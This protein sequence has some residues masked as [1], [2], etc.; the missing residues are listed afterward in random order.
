M[1]YL[2]DTNIVSAY[3]KG[4]QLVFNQLRNASRDNRVTCIS[5]IT[6]YEIRRGLLYTNATRQLALFDGFCATS[7]IL[8]LDNLEMIEIAARIHVDLSRRGR[9][10]QDNDI[11]IAATAIANNLTLVSNDTD[12]QNI[13]PL[14]L[15]NWL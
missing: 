6:Y 10:I 13:Q 1:G 9:P 2:L 5:C 8:L 14:S 15:E 4:N 11:L 3:L 12:L 7:E